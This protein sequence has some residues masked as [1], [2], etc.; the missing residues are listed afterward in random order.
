MTWFKVDDNLAFHRKVVASGNA[1][2]GLWVRAGAW[3]AQ[4]LTDGFI[5]DDMIS[6]LGTTAQAQRLI[7]SGLWAEVDGGCQFH[8]WNEKGRQPTGQSVREEREKSANRQAKW[9]STKSTDPQV[10]EPGNGVTHA[11][12]TG[13]VTGAVTP[14]PTRPDPYTSTDV[15]VAPQKRRR[16][17]RIPDDFQ[18]TT[19][20]ITWCRSNAPGIDGKRE[21]EKFVD[22]WRGKP[23]ASAVKVDWVS[24]W[25]NWIRRAADDLET[26]RPGPSNVRHLP[27]GYDPDGVMR[28]PKTGVAIER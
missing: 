25:R 3:C 9:R 6:L 2:M 1:A 8:Q 19:D 28:D 13:A 14:T 15:D 17:T 4:H 10:S 26:R 18:V 5:P 27:R 7:K 21:T 22:Y 11:L 24:T 12:V 23:G 16:A 20:M